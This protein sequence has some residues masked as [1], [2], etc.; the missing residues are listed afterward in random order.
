MT[1]ILFT[2]QIIEDRI[3]NIMRGND[4]IAVYFFFFFGDTGARTHDL[5][6][7]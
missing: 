7:G 6:L 3:W 1:I 5:T 2:Y 4:F